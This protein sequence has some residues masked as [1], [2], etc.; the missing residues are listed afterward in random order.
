MGGR[1]TPHL[2]VEGTSL[3]H[4]LPAHA[5]LLG[6]L[7]FVLATVALPPTAP[8]GFPLSVALVLGVLASTGVPAGQVLRRMVV[9]VPFVVF[10][11]VLPFVAT[12]PRVQVGPLSFSEPGL[13]GAAL[14]LAKATIGVLAAIAFATTT[15]PRDLVRALQALRLPST[16]VQILAFMV[17]YLGVVTDE[18]ARMRVARESRGFQ[19]RTVSAWPAVATSAGALFLRSYERGERVHLAM[20]SRG[21]TGA[22]PVTDPLRASARDW[23]VALS[24]AALVVAASL[25]GWLR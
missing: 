13:A 23:L 7:A 14:L 4:R 1:P 24:P 8:W 12:G 19:A 25:V 17:R 9:E 21:Y 16:L 11:L 3:V 6:L 5:K 15:D 22:L 2:H 20:L 10:A 18:M